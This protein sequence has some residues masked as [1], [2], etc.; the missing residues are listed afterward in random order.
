MNLINIDL[1]KAYNYLI[2]RSSLDCFVIFGET[3]NNMDENI[4]EAMVDFY[5][6]LNIQLMI[7]VSPEKVSI[8][9]LYVDTKLLL[10]FDKEISDIKSIIR[11]ENHE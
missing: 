6:N 7:F 9:S 10:A 4:I 2:K 5:N 11:S 3:F 8:I 1:D